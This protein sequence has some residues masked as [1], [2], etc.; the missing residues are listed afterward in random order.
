MTTPPDDGG[1][2]CPACG[3]TGSV[4]NEA[5]ALFQRWALDAFELD[6]TTCPD[7]KAQAIAQRFEAT[8]GPREA[9]CPL[10][11]PYPQNSDE[12]P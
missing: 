2:I 5:W 12:H 3:D 10:C 4:A 7:E 8:F 6:I 9:P 1:Q 11:K